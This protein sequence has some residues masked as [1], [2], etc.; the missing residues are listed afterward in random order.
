MKY[1]G[2]L[3]YEKPTSDLGYVEEEDER[4]TETTWVNPKA[5]SFRLEMV[6]RVRSLVSY[7][8]RWGGPRNREVKERLSEWETIRLGMKWWLQKSLI[9][10]SPVFLLEFKA[11]LRTIQR[12]TFAEHPNGEWAERA[13]KASPCWS[14]NRFG[15]KIAFSRPI[16][17]DWNDLSGMGSIR[18]AQSWLL[19]VLAPFCVC[20]QHQDATTKD[21]KSPISRCEMNVEGGLDEYQKVARGAS[22]D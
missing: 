4:E 18:P 2:K 16:E 6:G 7:N 15:S 10:D 20:T 9:F 22:K 1:G 19:V 8:Q 17:I 5:P 11:I 13:K 12:Y 21:N 3:M 14:E